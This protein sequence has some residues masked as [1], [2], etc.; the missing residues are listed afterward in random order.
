MPPPPTVMTRPSG[1][2]L[3]PPHDGLAIASGMFVKVPVVGSQTKAVSPWL[4]SPQVKT[5]PL[6]SKFPCIETM[7]QLVIRLPHWPV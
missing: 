3:S 2:A 1:R 7:G 5:L 6:G 4:L